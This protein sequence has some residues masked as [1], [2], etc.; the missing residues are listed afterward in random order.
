M[1]LDRRPA[2]E[3]KKAAHEEG[4]RFLRESAVEKVLHGTD[5]AARNQQGDVRRM[6]TLSAL[7]VP[8][9]RGRGHRDR[10]G[11]GVGRRCSRARGQEALV[12]GY[13]VEPLPPGAVVRVADDAEHRRSAR[14]WSAASA[15]GRRAPARRSRGA[16]R[17]C[18]R[19]STARVSLVRFEQVPP[20][21]EDLE[22]LVRWQVK[23]A[24]PFPIDDAV[25][26][27]HAG[28]DRRR[29]ADTEFL[30]VA[31][32]TRH[33]ARLREPSAKSSTCRPGSSISRRS[34]W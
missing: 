8:S 7:L 27:V 29:M 21:A 4:M 10:S 28:G 19:I 5:D 25:L 6:S 2:S 33:R 11:G 24:A 26:T 30:V 20:R 23:K 12:Q 17:C 13:V 22:Q 9:A 18:C 15:R 1:I 34:A 3:V 31:G 32:A 14:R 16:W